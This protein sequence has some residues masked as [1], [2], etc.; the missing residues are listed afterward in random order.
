MT[1]KKPEYEKAET[2]ETTCYMYRDILYVPHY[3]GQDAFVGPGYGTNHRNSY[4][5]D[6]LLSVGAVE[7]TRPLWKRGH[8]AVVEK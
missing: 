5:A 7:I 8:V 4:T 1:A 3:N 2:F 6:F